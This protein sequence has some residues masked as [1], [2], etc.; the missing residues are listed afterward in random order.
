[1]LEEHLWSPE[2]W[3]GTTAVD[4]PGILT[5]YDRL[6]GELTTP[7]GTKTWLFSQTPVSVNLA[8]QSSPEAMVASGMNQHGLGASGP[9]GPAA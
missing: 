5:K 6:K 2:Q 1:M 7:S 8:S 3:L 4:R 9:G